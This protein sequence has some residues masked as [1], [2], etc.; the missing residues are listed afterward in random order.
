[1]TVLL[2][3]LQFPNQKE[4]RSLKGKTLECSSLIILAVGKE[5]FAPDAAGFIK[6]LQTL[7]ES[8]TDTDDPQ[9]SY[10]LSAWARVCKVLGVE[11]APYLNIVLP[12][13]LKTAG[14]QANMVAF[15]ADDEI[16]EEYNEEEGWEV[17]AVGNKVWIRYCYS[18]LESCHQNFRVR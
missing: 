9:S 8:V 13:L 14:L 3:I 6:V 11:F 15:D 12:P 18:S 2:Q 4:Y 1:M 17:M 7:Q 16:G 5:T 10:L